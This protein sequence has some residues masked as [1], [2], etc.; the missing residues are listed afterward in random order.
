MGVILLAKER[1]LI[2]AI[3][4]LLDK[5]RRTPF[6]MTEELYQKMLHMAGEA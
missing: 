1:G 3:K 4:P 6:R 5:L 2:S